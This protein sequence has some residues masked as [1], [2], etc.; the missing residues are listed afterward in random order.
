[1]SIDSNKALVRRYYDEVLSAGK[2]EVLAELLAPSFASHGA[3]GR[4]FGAEEYR[5]AVV[6]SR[7]AFPDLRVTIEDQIAEGDKV[8]TRWTARGMHE[9]AYFGLPA[10]HRLIVVSAIHIHRIADGKL[11]EHWEQIDVAG[12]LRQ[13]GFLT[14]F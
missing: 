6:A 14:Y 1:V 10:T 9:A 2:I 7:T 8:V 3:D 5:A 4:T 12:V 11:A 13:M